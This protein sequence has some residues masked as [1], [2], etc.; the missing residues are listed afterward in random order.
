MNAS[1]SPVSP[2]AINVADTGSGDGGRAARSAETDQRVACHEA[3]HAVVARLIGLELGGVTCEPSGEFSGMCWGPGRAACLSE[4]TDDVPALFDKLRQAMPKA[5]EK[6]DVV[7]GE[8]LQFAVNRLV[9][10]AAGSAGET[11]LVGNCW[12][13]PHDR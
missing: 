10:I 6:R 1:F 11:M 5:G 4:S 9:E 8:I 3:S 13:S 12:P 2:V 7:T